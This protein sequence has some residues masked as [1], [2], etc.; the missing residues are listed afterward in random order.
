V[1]GRLEALKLKE[2]PEED[3]RRAD[4]HGAWDLAPQL[5]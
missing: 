3:S 5:H 4:M 2:E 1:Q